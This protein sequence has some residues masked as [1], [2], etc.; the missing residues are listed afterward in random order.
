MLPAGLATVDD[1]FVKLMHVALEAPE[2]PVAVLALER[3]MP[4]GDWTET[5][6]QCL[7]IYLWK[8]QGKVST[9]IIV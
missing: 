2:A 5:I 6:G 7:F 4:F 8:N 3:N 1:C 9:K